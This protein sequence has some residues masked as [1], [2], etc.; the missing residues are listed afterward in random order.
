MLYKKTVLPIST[1]RDFLLYRE[2]SCNMCRIFNLNWG[3]C[4]ILIVMVFMSIRVLFLRIYDSIILLF[5]PRT[6]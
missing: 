4:H 2:Y 1:V 3:Y 5:L 6:A